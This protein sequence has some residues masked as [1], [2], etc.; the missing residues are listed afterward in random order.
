MG[1][2]DRRFCWMR[3]GCGNQKQESGRFLGCDLYYWKMEIGKNGK[4]RGKGVVHCHI[5]TVYQ[6]HRWT[7]T[8]MRQKGGFSLWL[9]GKERNQTCGGE[10]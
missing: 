7:S 9:M 8:G 6:D 1:S 5:P 10:D 3:Q 2:A 4:L